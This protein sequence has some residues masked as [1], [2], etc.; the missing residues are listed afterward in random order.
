MDQ[1]V[2]DQGLWSAEDFRKGCFM[3]IGTKLTAKEV[4]RLVLWAI[5]MASSAR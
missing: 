5:Q 4:Q 1:L 2:E 3:G